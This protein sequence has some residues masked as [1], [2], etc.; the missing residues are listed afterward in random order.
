MNSIA[1]MTDAQIQKKIGNKIKQQRLKQNI[2]QASLATAAQLS[3]S[4][5]K[6]IERGKIGSFDSLLRVLRIL[7]NMGYIAPLINDEQM[8]PNEYYEF[9][10]KQNKTLRKRA[11]GKV[12]NPKNK[13]SEW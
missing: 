7:K 4:T 6:S 13:I 8:S 2:T 11:V 9:V 5:I 1:I 3:L 10:N 12:I